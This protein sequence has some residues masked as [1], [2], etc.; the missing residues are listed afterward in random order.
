MELQLSRSIALSIAVDRNLYEQHLGN[1]PRDPLV[2]KRDPSFGELV[3]LVLFGLVTTVL[4][5]LSGGRVGSVLVK[6]G[7]GRTE[8]VS[9]L[10]HG[11]KSSWMNGGESGLRMRPAQLQLLLLQVERVR[12]GRA[13]SIRNELPHHRRRKLEPARCAVIP[14]ALREASQHAS[15]RCQSEVKGSKTSLRS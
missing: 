6:R 8:R 12:A 1:A 9:E 14:H 11:T 13:S 2:L 7:G 10:L 5:R 15:L 4:G 3:L